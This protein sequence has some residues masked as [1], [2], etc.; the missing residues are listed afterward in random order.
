M[1]K[2]M[3]LILGGVRS[4][5]SD[6][7]QSLLTATQQPVLFV[8]TAE[9]GD[10]EMANRIAAHRAG[11]PARW[12]TLEAHTRVGEAIKNAA[13]TP[14][15]L[16]DCI[17]LLASNVLTSCPEPLDE[18]LYLQKME[19]ELDELIAAYHDHSGIW[20]IVTNEVGL[21]LVPPYPLGRYYRDGLGK[22]NQK[23]AKFSDRVILMVAGIPLTVK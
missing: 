2:Q 11:R 13:I 1:G 9:A 18:K 21:G 15:V 6:Y 23:L 7:A 8:A 14:Y 4:G 20:V 3:T 19:S 22:V 12:I 17:T 10:D 5:K 16:L